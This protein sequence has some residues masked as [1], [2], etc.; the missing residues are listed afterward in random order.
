VHSMYL[1]FYYNFMYQEHE[2]FVSHHVDM[3][4]MDTKL[5]LRQEN[6]SQDIETGE[7]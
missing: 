2:I 6:R 5:Y 7:R 4:T 1:K 3:H